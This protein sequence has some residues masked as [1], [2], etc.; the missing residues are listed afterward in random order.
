[1][2]PPI[3]ELL[4]K[5]DS[6][7]TLVTLGA[8]RA[9]EINAYYHG[10]GEGLG[11]VIPPQVTSVSGKP[12]SIAFEEIAA[13]KVTYHHPDPEELA[14][15]AA[16][17]DAETLGFSAD[18]FASRA[19]QAGPGPH[20]SWARRRRWTGLTTQLSRSARP[21][22]RMAEAQRGPSSS[23][24]SPVASPPTRRSSSA[25]ASSTPAA[26]SHRCSPGMPALRRPA[27]LH[28]PGL[29]AGPDRALRTATHRSRTP[30]RPGG[31]PDRHRPGHR[32]PPRRATPTGWPTTC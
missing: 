3:E 23:W 7:F 24:A 29:R 30:A 14:A 16:A 12:L 10:L 21:E 6:K 4:D 26:T 32:P 25:A 1:M 31:R 27:D 22:R 20:A 13:A 28:R 17:G 2:D 8:K 18:P 11:Q 19:T 9:R 5:V 15:E